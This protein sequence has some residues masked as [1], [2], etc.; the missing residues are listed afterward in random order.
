MGYSAALLAQTFSLVVRLAGTLIQGLW[1]VPS[2]DVPHLLPVLEGELSSLK[3]GVWEELWE[4]WE[5]LVYQM[6]V[7][8]SQLMVGRVLDGKVPSEAGEACSN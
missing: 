7:L 2:G 1:P 6:D 3:R 8:E 4:V 5:W